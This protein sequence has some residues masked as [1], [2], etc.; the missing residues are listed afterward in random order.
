MVV[1]VDYERDSYDDVQ[2]RHPGSIQHPYTDMGSLPGVKPHDEGLIYNGHDIIN[3]ADKDEKLPDSRDDPNLNAFSRCLACYP[4]V[5]E[6]ARYLDLNTLDALSRTC[7]QIRA[8]LIPYSRQLVKRTLRCE[9]QYNVIL[10]ELLREGVS[11]SEG[12]KLANRSINDDAP[13]NGRLRWGISGLCARDMVGECQRCSKVVCRNCTVKPPRA[14]MARNR[15]RRL[16][17]T[18][19]AAPIVY[20]LFPGD[21]VPSTQLTS[22]QQSTQAFTF[23]AFARTPCRCQDTLWLCESCG[24]TLSKNDSTYRRVWTW[25]TRYGTY[26]GTGLG[27]GIGEGFQGVKCGKG[28]NCLAASA[29]E[30][31]V[32]CEVDESAITIPHLHNYDS[33]GPFNGH[34]ESPPLI[35]G[36]PLSERSDGHQHDDEPGYL[37]QEI[38]GI[39]GVVK[40]KVKKRV[41]VGACVEE[42][43][44]ERETGKYLQREADGLERSWC[45]W[46][47]R[48]VPSRK[49]WEKEVVPI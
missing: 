10:N 26:L 47:W 13:K 15:L 40:R 30:L 42:Y 48:V 22:L 39:G 29:I 27:T 34:V 12:V 1:F 23:S 8:N 31:E 41:V 6:L 35:D 20:H 11:L 46:C 43:E 33:D 37:R 9:T 21:K 25:R 7:R 2:H 14:T 16:C 45:G 49:D 4:V 44:D 19:C 38:V 17:K 28:E 24:F 5:R 32:D 36:L 18:C 3:G